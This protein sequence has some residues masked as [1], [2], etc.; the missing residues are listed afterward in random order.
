MFIGHLGCE[1]EMPSRCGGRVGGWCAL[2]FGIVRWC[3]VL[4]AI[5]RFCSSLFGQTRGSAPTRGKKLKDSE[6]ARLNIYN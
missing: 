6:L 1:T 4:F 2:G 3:L 5:V